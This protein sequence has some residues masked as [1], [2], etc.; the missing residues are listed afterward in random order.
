MLQRSCSAAQWWQAASDNERFQSEHTSLLNDGQDIKTVRW[1]SELVLMLSLL[2]SR[3]LLY[4]ALLKFI[5]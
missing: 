5:M 2:P 4:T 3:H 1:V